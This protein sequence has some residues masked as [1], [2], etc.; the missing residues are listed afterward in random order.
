MKPLIIAHRGNSV[1]FQDNTWNAIISAFEVGA[2]MCEV[3]LQLTSDNKIFIAHDYYLEGKRIAQM[4]LEECKALAPDNPSLEELVN[5]AR[6]ENRRFLLEVK[7]RRM[8]KELLNILSSPKDKELFMIGSFDLVFMA[9]LQTHIPKCILLG[10]IMSAKYTHA[11]ALECG[12][13]FVLPAWENRHPYPH[14][15]LKEEFIPY[16]EERNIKVIAW[17]EERE[18]V[19]RELLSMNLYGICTNDPK[20]LRRL[21]HEGGN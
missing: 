12:A 21:S 7:D 16:L 10:S 9:R 5:Y 14:E 2:D 15:L 1:E 19:L 17:H 20:L 8:D 11:L 3:D 6:E 13:E 4:S 18:E